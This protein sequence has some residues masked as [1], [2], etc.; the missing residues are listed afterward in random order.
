MANHFSGFLILTSEGTRSEQAYS[1]G[2]LSGRSIK[3][4]N[5]GSY[6]EANF[7]NGELNGEMKFY[8]SSNNLRSTIVYKNGKL[9]PPN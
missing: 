4:N 3:K 8:D 2:K 7:H 5:D 1:E 9:L 6:V